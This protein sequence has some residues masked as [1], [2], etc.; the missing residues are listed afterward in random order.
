MSEMKYFSARIPIPKDF[1][2]GALSKKFPSTIFHI[3][4]SKQSG[5]KERIVFVKSKDPKTE[6][7]A[8]LKNHKDVKR[9]EKISNVYKIHVE[10]Y[11]LK[12]IDQKEIN[13]LHPTT[14]KNGNHIVQFL[15]RSEQIKKLKKAFPK[16][17]LIKVS[18][19]LP[20]QKLLTSRQMEIISTASSLGYYSYPRKITLTELAR[21]FEISK[22]TL[23]QTLRSA[24][25]KA[26]KKLL[27]KGIESQ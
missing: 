24:E 20:K 19:E 9:I 3:I 17:N 21:L 27:R 5:N 26:V 2:L 25:N 1:V 12:K 15:L 4:S 10:S 8:F 16:L 18:N 11:L 14:L 22:A 13:V 23:S 6:E 7:Y